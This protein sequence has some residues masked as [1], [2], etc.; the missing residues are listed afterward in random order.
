M[1]TKICTKCAEEKCLAG[2]YNKK[3]GK[4]GK[5]AECKIC[6][7]ESAKRWA[8]ENPSKKKQK[9]IQEDTLRRRLTKEQVEEAKLLGKTSL[10]E[11]KLA[12]LKK[13]YGMKI[14]AMARTYLNG[15]IQQGLI[16]KPMICEECGKDGIIHGHH[17]DYSK[18]LD[19][20][21]LCPKCHAKIERG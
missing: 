5:H 3:A 10:D 6:R 12:H 13:Y 17:S 8:E 1:I 16:I 15:V 9:R 11:S 4:Y 2:F 7:R 14:K 18:P 21:W 20:Q 19:V